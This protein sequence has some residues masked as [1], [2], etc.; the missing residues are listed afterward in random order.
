MTGA[1]F[2]DR[3]RFAAALAM[4]KA[5]NEEFMDIMKRMEIIESA[6]A[7]AKELS[8][9]QNSFGAW[10]VLE[11]VYREHPDDQELNRMR[12]DFA[13]KASVF[14]SAVSKAEEAQSRGDFSKALFSYLEAKELY[15]AS[16]FVQEGIQNTVSELLQGKLN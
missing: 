8:R 6:M 5:R 10:E 12:G 4:D 15:P 1:I 13:V 3:F 2:N 7:Q 11:R 16:F 14:A 9:I